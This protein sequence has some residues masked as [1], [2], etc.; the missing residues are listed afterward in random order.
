MLTGHCPVYVGRFACDWHRLS[1]TD[2]SSTMLII[3]PMGLPGKENLLEDE[4]NLIH[5][6]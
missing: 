5:Q 1:T 3:S 6:H 2:R 4:E